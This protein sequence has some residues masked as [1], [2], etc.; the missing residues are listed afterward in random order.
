MV[1]FLLTMKDMKTMKGIDIIDVCGLGW[2][3]PFQ[4][5]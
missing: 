2:I 4:D 5:F 3:P 1:N